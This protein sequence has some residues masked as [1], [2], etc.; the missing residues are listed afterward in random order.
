MGDIDK[1]GNIIALEGRWRNPEPFLKRIGAMMVGRVKSTFKNQGRDGVKWRERAVPNVIGVIRDME[2][3]R[4][5]IP[6]RR[7]ESRPAGRDTGLLQRSIAYRIANERIVEIGSTLNYA[8]DVQQGGQRVVRISSV[9][10]NNLR[11]L[12][13]KAKK[14]IA[15]GTATTKDQMIA[16]LGWLLFRSSFKAKVPA[17]PYVFFSDLDKSDIAREAARYFGRPGGPPSSA[18]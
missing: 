4:K 7:F 12:V 1:G 8:T 9:A 18:A 10:R 5:S 3:G 17:R 6:A 15:K 2:A 14:K 16:M 13:E 11:V